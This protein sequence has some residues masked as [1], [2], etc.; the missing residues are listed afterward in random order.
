MIAMHGSKA[1]S[2]GKQHGDAIRRI[3][4]IPAK[5]SAD[6]FVLQ[7]IAP[8]IANS[9]PALEL[10]TDFA[11]P[12]IAAGKRNLRACLQRTFLQPVPHALECVHFLARRARNRSPSK[13][14]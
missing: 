12:S 8:G 4:F 7:D 1:L 2:P 11:E 6:R 14:R 10:R 3:I 9:E 5:N 13:T